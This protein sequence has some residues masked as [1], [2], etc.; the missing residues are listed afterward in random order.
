M[1]NDIEI[2]WR[3][4]DDTDKIMEWVINTDKAEDTSK[5]NEESKSNKKD[6]NKPDPK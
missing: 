1:G 6:L 4:S 3:L 2:K 5:N